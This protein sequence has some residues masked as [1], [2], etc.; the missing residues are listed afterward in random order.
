MVHCHRA[1][2]IPLFIP[3]LCMPPWHSRPPHVR[4]PSSA[5]V[6]LRYPTWMPCDFVSPSTPLRRRFDFFLRLSPPRGYPH[7][8]NLKNILVLMIFI[9]FD[10]YAYELGV[11]TVLAG[12][13]ALLLGLLGFV[14]VSL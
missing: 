10:N 4:Y 8:R 7:F 14:I 6:H 12:I 2:L 1:A 11:K 3:S 9:I 5:L 13:L